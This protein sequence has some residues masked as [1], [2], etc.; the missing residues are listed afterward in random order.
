MWPSSRFALS[1]KPSV[2]Y[3]A[4]N[5]CALWKQRSTLPSL[6]TPAAR[7]RFSAR[8]LARW[9]GDGMKPLG[10]SAIRFLHLGDLRARR[11]P[12]RFVR[13]RA[14]TR[15]RFQPLSA[16]PHRALFLVRESLRLR[17]GRGSAF[18]RLLLPFFAGFI[19]LFFQ[20]E[21]TSNCFCAL[22]IHP[23]R[24][25]R[26]RVAYCYRLLLLSQ[27]RHLCSALSYFTPQY[28][29]SLPFDCFRPW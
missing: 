22:S 8:G 18:G 12:R 3:L 4:L 19:A 20:T 7:I 16:L 11:F 13:A 10:H 17:S 6:H 9:L 24:R 5:C 2:A 25:R 26:A 21:V 29:P 14:A 23:V 27:H 15:S 28:S 1:L